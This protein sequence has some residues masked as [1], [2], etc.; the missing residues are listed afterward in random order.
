MTRFGCALVVGTLLAGLGIWPASPSRSAA[1]GDGFFAALEDLPVMP[2]L[3]ELAERGV[4]FDAPEGRIVEV[5][6]EGTVGR[7]DVLGFY[8]STL[9]QLGWRPAGP[10]DFRR[11]GE[12]LILEF[13]AGG[14]AG[15]LLVRFYLAPG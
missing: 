12:R 4:V 7:E 9:P 3:V 5:Y 14:A 11:E 10:S 13:P 6:A 1:A 15:R 8:A 2:G